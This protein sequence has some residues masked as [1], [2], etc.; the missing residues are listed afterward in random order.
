VLERA[1]AIA[2]ASFGPRHFEVARIRAALG[3]NEYRMGNYGAAREL[4]ERALEIH[5][6]AFG[7]THRWVGRVQYSLACIAALAGDREEAI[8]DLRR[9]LETDWRW[10]GVLDDPDLESLRGDP[11]ADAILAELA[12]GVQSD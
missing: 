5:R 11:E 6:G 12:G 4:Y 10:A 2:E 7:P 3:Y 8:A 9:T 1:L